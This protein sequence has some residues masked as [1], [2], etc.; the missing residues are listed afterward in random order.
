MI[1]VG[2]PSEAEAKRLK[3]AYEDAI[4]STKA[5]VTFGI[6]PRGSRRLHDGQSPVAIRLQDQQP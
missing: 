4:E 2:A 3:E 1:R 5:A 6:V